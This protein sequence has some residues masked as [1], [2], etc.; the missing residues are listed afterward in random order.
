MVTGLLQWSRQHSAL[1]EERRLPASYEEIEVRPPG[2]TTGTVLLAWHRHKYRD[3]DGAAG[4]A[5]GWA[6]T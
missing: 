5:W 6:Q 1:F 2:V 3:R 4:L